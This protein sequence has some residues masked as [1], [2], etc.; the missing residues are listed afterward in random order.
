[1]NKLIRDVLDLLRF[2]IQ[3]LSHYVYPAW[4]PLAWIA[5]IGVVGAASAY[6]FQAGFIA[7]VGFFVVLNLL[8][9]LLLSF[10]LMGWWRWILK[11]P[12]NCSLF[13]LVVLVSS[14]QLL[15]PLTFLLPENL[16]MAFAFP[17]AVY[18]VVLLVVAVAQALNER[19][20]LVV[21]AIIGYLPV[22]L[23][24]LHFA[25]NLALD[26]GWV[27]LETTTPVAGSDTTLF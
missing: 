2:R 27:S 10:W 22:A 24:L 20:A 13:P 16:S 17:L 3:P 11:R 7:R 23:A 6:E 25:M 26:W 21:A 4:Q 18:G 19:R 1:M 14:T 5:L 8:E 15:E 9:T 12:I